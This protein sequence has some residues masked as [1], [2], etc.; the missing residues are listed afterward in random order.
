MESGGPAF[1]WSQQPR[2]SNQEH[3]GW[4]CSN[5]PSR[6]SQIGILD[7]RAVLDEE[8]GQEEGLGSQS[9]PAEQTGSKECHTG[10]E[11]R[12]NQIGRSGA[13]IHCDL[14]YE[15]PRSGMKQERQRTRMVRGWRRRGRLAYIWSIHLPDYLSPQPRRRSSVHVF[16]QC[17]SATLFW[18]CFTQR[19]TT[20]D[21][22][23][24][25]ISSSS[26]N[27]C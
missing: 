2:G 6:K 24:H 23:W 25:S 7:P 27:L 17:P 22:W 8:R 9:S 4:S 10:S 3:R 13:E 20:R 14:L 18:E 11:Q 12:A 26:R 1:L 5:A 16:H 21:W 19:M 15:E